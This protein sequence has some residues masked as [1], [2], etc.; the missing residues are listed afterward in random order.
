M[1]ISTQELRNVVLGK[2]TPD[3][4]AVAQGTFS[5]SSLPLGY[6][7]AVPTNP[8]N[9]WFQGNITSN[10]QKMIIQHKDIA[11]LLLF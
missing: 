10:Q 5:S 6:D 1:N 2:L 4:R 8:I 7:N 11:A 9:V 3:E